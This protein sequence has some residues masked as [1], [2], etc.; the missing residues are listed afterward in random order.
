MKK[1]VILI[2]ATILSVLFLLTF[3]EKEQEV[4][5][6]QADNIRFSLYN[7]PNDI[8]NINK[9]STREKDIICATSIGLVEIDSSNKI[10]PSLAKETK[11]SDDGIEYEFIFDESKIWSNGER[12]IPED[13]ISFIKDMIKN[14]DKDDIESLLNIYGAQDYR[15]GS[16]TFEKGVAIQKYE[17]G[18][19]IRL[20]KKDD[21]FL[22]ELSKPQYRLRKNIELWENIRINYNK[23]IYS[24]VYKIDYIDKNQIKLSARDD[25]LKEIL[26]TREENSELAMAAFDIGERDVVLSPPKNI[27]NR[28]K[29]EKKLYT[30]SSKRGVYAYLNKSKEGFSLNQRKLAFKYLNSAISEYCKSNE[31]YGENSYGFYNNESNAG[32]KIQSRKVLINNIQQIKM[33]EVL[34]LIAIDNNENRELC[35]YLA[36][37]VKEKYNVGIRYTLVNELEFSKKDVREQYHIILFQN[38]ISGKDYDFSQIIKELMD[39]ED[40]QKLV[41]NNY[42]VNKI[43]SELFNNFSLVSLMFYKENVAI[44]NEVIKIEFDG[45][46]NIKFDKVQ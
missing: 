30:T 17:N 11:V 43:E 15:N 4:S 44:S 31:Y 35:E 27:L 14:A 16:T 21:N 1:I 9:L 22:K 8:K 7:I 39:E 41:D 23:I 18:I 2:S 13:Y 12:I 34:T 38:M 36:K 24:G 5:N 45:N 6:K 46:G 20:N 28:L 37:T 32:E 40:K 19:K 26:F 33:P 29:E 10:I 42:D 3:V 25:S